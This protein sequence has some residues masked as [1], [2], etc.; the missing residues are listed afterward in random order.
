MIETILFAIIVAK[1][2]KYKVE[3]LFKT[4]VFYPILII[5]G[6]NWIGQAFIFS[7]NYSFVYIMAWSK[8]LYLVSY[9]FLIFKYELY[10]SAL[11][12][13]GFVIAGGVLN[14]IAISSNGGFM[15][16]FPSISYLTGYVKPESFEI[17]KDIHILGNSDTNLKFLTDFIDLGYSILSVGDIFIRVFVF[18]IIY[19]SI[20]SAN[21]L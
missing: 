5:E 2:K 20:K 1:I 14:D 11:I 19:N 7:G 17:V 3:K 21:K 6:L 9:L 8:T 12:G 18:L 13:S 10:K 15:P 16:V 4:W